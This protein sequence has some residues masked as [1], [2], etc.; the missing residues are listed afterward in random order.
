MLSQS[1]A[2]LVPARD[3][4]HPSRYTQTGVPCQANAQLG[5]CEC[6][7]ACM[8]A[9]RE[10]RDLLE[11]CRAHRA[12][13]LAYYFSARA[14]G[15]VCGPSASFDAEELRVGF[16]WLVPRPVTNS[17]AVLFG[18]SSLQI[19]ILILFLCFLIVYIHLQTVDG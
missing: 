4:C 10:A 12:F 3:S 8:H 9:Y 2:G 16:R 7:R 6:M 13:F 15:E 5:L 17:G 14:W 19:N 11:S 18:C 1:H